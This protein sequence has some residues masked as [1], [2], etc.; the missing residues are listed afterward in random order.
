MFTIVIALRIDFKYPYASV[1]D[2]STLIILQRQQEC[3]V[4]LLYRTRNVILQTLY[5]M[6]DEEIDSLKLASFH[7]LRFPKLSSPFISSCRVSAIPIH[8]VVRNATGVGQIADLNGR[9]FVQLFAV[10]TV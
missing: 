5:R 10:R 3:C 4:G 6:L 9:N 7:D 2:K 8:L 1:V